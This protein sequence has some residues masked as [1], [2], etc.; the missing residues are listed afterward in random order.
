MNIIFDFD[1]TL[2]RTE[3]VDI[4]AINKALSDMG[5]HTKTK[6]EILSLIGMPMSRI[7]RQLLN[8]DDEKQ[9]KQLRESVIRNELVLIPRF[10]RM[11]P[12]AL[13]YLSRLMQEGHNM[14]ICSNGS[15]LYIQKL[16]EQFNLKQYFEIVWYRKENINKTEAARQVGQT[17]PPDELT[18]LVGDRREDVEAAHANGFIAI[19][20]AYGFGEREELLDANY[21]AEDLK[22][23]YRIISELEEQIK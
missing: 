2:F 23:I 15:K 19:G 18:V 6:E 20:A 10:A 13:E 17:L 4:V 21:I 8:S 12:F 7:S 11:Y 9:N 1:G 3:T 14:A 16:I 22:D 5:K